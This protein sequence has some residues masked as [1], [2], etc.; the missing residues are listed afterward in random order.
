ML[1]QE[2]WREGALAH[3]FVLLVF[4]QFLRLVEL[5]LVLLVQDLIALLRRWVTPGKLHASLV[6]H[7][8]EAAI[9]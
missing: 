2:L 6:D 3:L 5:L 9:L 7:G 1:G 8:L 4:H